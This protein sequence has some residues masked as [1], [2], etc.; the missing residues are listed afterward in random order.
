VWVDKHK[1]FP[2]DR[3]WA[4]GEM[5]PQLIITHFVHLAWQTQ[6]KM[7]RWTFGK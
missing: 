1:G 7:A 4:V 5:S 3:V 6:Q 2:E